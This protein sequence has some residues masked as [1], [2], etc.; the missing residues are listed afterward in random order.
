M[1]AKPSSISPGFNSHSLL[2]STAVILSALLNLRC[3]PEIGD[4]CETSLD[5]DVQNNRVC[6]LTQPRGYCTLEGCEKG[7]CPEDSV[8]VMF[9]PEPERLSS[10]WCMA[11]CDDNDDCRKGYYCRRADQLKETSVSDGTTKQEVF[12]KNLDKG[13]AKF[14]TVRP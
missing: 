10:T 12:A 9:R 6:D 5:C 7:T 3:A 4:E 14:C 11:S 13:S 1:S 8:C 2:I